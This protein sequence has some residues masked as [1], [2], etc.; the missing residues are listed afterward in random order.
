MPRFT[1]I[2]CIVWF[3]TAHSLCQARDAYLQSSR[4][5]EGDI[6]ELIIQYDGAIPSLY[7]LDTS[8]LETD[9]EV[10]SVKSR[11][12]RVIEA[13]EVF[14]RMHWE[15]Q[16]LPRRNG[17]LK[18]PALQVGDLSTPELTLEVVQP[19]LELSSRNSVFVEMQA[20]PTNPYPGQQVDVVMR[21]F[22]N[23]SLFDGGLIEPETREA[24][25]YRS[26]V[27]TNYSVTHDGRKYS[28]LERSIA[29]VARSPGELIIPPT[30]YRGR[31][32]SE[33]DTSTGD[34]AMKTRRINRSSEALQLQVR[35]LPPGFS[36]HSWLPARQLSLEQHWDK[37]DA[38]LKVG[39]SLGLT[40]T[41]EA[42][43]LAA[44]ALPANTNV[45]GTICALGSRNAYR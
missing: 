25:I 7:A 32:K 19:S 22:H 20:N 24:E 26:G 4:I 36:D 43:G 27:D 44:A 23:L 13:D 1:L 34:S 3:S 41:I 6:A 17:S 37:F 11:L 45:R 12:A 10:L 21:L 18:I 38:E 30:I 2:C 39:D 9:F 14:H 42:R 8:V 29:L 16:I 5:F 15:L 31:I 28:V 35:N 33:D 40:L